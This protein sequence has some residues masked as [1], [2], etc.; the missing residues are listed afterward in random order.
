M[1]LVLERTPSCEGGMLHV[2]SGADL[3]GILDSRENPNLMKIHT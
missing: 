1:R 3:M 2:Y